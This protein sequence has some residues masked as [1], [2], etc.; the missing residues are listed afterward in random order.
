MLA[1]SYQGAMLPGSLALFGL[2]SIRSASALSANKARSRAAPSS[3]ARRQTQAGDTRPK[4][5]L[6]DP[7]IGC[8]QFPVVTPPRK[9]VERPSP[10]LWTGVGECCRKGAE[11]MSSS[12][13]WASRWRTVD[14][15]LSD[16]AGP[17][18]GSTSAV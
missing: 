10:G 17:W 2:S 15:R 4:E 8:S 16:A 3:E 12:R 18:M 11:P 9:A 5:G 14:L 6:E 13:E 1:P 7:G